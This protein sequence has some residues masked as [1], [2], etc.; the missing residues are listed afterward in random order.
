MDKRTF[1][2]LLRLLEQGFGLP[3]AFKMLHID[4][5][6]T[7]QIMNNVEFLQE[8]GKSFVR[9]FD[10][11]TRTI[12]NYRKANKMMSFDNARQKLF[13]FETELV[14]WE[15]R[16]TKEAFEADYHTIL[17]LILKAYNTP[18]SM[19]TSV[20]YT[21]DEFNAL[22]MDNIPLVQVLKEN[23]KFNL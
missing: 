13:K 19:A 20:G 23:D 12:D 15:C 6:E 10:A 9:A 1:D 14:Y 8:V 17:P 18:L 3:L 2:I 16:C 5:K 4:I 7:T 22:I 21:L 11:E